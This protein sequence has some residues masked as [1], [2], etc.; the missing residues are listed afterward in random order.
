MLSDSICRH[1][2]ISLG[3][4]PCLTQHTR[5]R[6]R[7]EPSRSAGQ[8]HSHGGDSRYGFSSGR[9]PSDTAGGHH[10]PGAARRRPPAS[11]TGSPGEPHPPHSQHLPYQTLPHDFRANGEPSPPR[12]A[13]REHA[14]PAPDDARARG[15]PAARGARV[16]RAASAAAR[17]AR[18]PRV[19]SARLAAGA[20]FPSRPA[21]GPHGAAAAPAQFAAGS[22]GGARAAAGRASQDRPQQQASARCGRYS[23]LRPRLWRP[24]AELSGPGRWELHELRQELYVGQA[25]VGKY[26]VISAYVVGITFL[27]QSNI[28]LRSV[29]ICLFHQCTAFE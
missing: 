3:I 17:G 11:P 28:K 2:T 4:W 15:V 29:G 9:Y 10:S 18:A 5:C 6:C 1:V 8:R 19:G 24:D 22:P 13:G 7:Q 23:Q 14:S 16:T 25:K 27:F 12:G 21:D 20:G 26:H